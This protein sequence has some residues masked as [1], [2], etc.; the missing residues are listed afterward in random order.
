[1]VTVSAIC[2][3]FCFCFA[4][5]LMAAKDMRYGGR[6]NASTRVAIKSSRHESPRGTLLIQY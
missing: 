2:E 1:M 5:L 3:I 4:Q 6:E